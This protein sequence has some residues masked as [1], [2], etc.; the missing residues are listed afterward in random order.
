MT[1]SKP[2]VATSK[3]AHAS[4]SA[5][6]SLALCAVL[7]PAAAQASNGLESPD[8][9]VVQLGRGGAWLA[10]AEDPLAFFYNPAALAW[11]PHG[12]HL[13]MHFLFRSQ[14]FDRLDET[15][16]R[17]SPG[18]NLLPAPEPVCADALPIPNPQLAASIRLHRM[19]AL[20]F[21][22]VAPHNAGMVEWP[23]VINYPNRFGLETDHPSPQR[24]LL[25]ANKSLLLFPTVSLG[26]SPIDELSFG[27]GF[28]WG[29]AR[30]EFS[31]MNEA[32]SGV[33]GTPQP[34]DFSQ[35]VKSTIDGEDG[36]IPGF[37][38][39]ILA[40]P[41]ERFDIAAWYR[42]SDKLRAD[43]D[44]YAQSNYYNAG[45][46]VN[47]VAI[48]D[49]ANITDVEDVGRLGLPIPMEAK[50]G[51]RYRHPRRSP[52]VQDWVRE[53]PGKVSDPMSMELFDVELDLTW[54]HNSQFENIEL[55]FD[56]GIVIRG[57]PGNIPV[58]GDIPHKWQDVFGFRIGGDYNIIEDFLSLRM[59]GFFESKGVSDEYL[60]VDFQPGMRGGIGGGLTIRASMVDITAAYQHTFYS[61]LDNGGQGQILAISGDLTT[62][63]RSRQAVNG[64][65]MTANLNEIAIGA[66]AHF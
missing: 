41:H 58:N 39:G 62:G 42:F 31:N 26:V 54:A 2:A 21:G 35:D 29:V 34:D 50:L 53:Q 65:S 64:G 3:P 23:E 4:L 40:E 61:T 60:H 51:F 46:T 17:P 30:A 47:E 27:A 25:I 38:I 32:V 9:G 6:V 10:R 22:V 37:V 66:T 7:A 36:F 14:C 45:G 18:Q 55:A 44:L 28:T 24:Y 13:G 1:K 57:T 59:G 63:N 5:A 48:E 8:I 33:R 19:V 56:P 43:V 16:N 11:Q 20:G 12:V 15:G 52:Q 49:P